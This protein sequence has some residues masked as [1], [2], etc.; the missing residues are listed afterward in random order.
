MITLGGEHGGAV[1]NAL[2]GG[3]AKL[4]GGTGS[5]L[6]GLTALL[7]GGLLLSGAS[8]GAVLRR[9]HHAVRRAVA[10]PEKV[11]DRHKVT[12]ELIGLGLVAIGLFLASLLYLGW[13][14]GV[15]GEKIE[16]G[17]RDVI[18]SAAY[19]AP[20]ALVVVGGLMLFRSALLDVNPFR[21]G[22]V[23]TTIGLMVTLGGD[24]GGAVGG[25]LG[26][27]VAK[28]L[29]GTGSVLLGLTALLAGALML[30]GASYGAVLR[31][32]HHAVRRAV[33]RPDR[34]KRDEVL[35][36]PPVL[37]Q[38]E[39]PID[40]VHDYPDVVSEGLS[41]PPPLL[42]DSDD[43]TE[44]QTALFDVPRAEGAY[45]LPDRAVLKVSPPAAVEHEGRRPAHG[46]HARDRARAL[47]RRGDDRRPDRR[48]A[49]HPLRAAAR[50]GNEGV[51]G[52]GPEGRPLLR[53]R[54]DR[55]PD[56]GADPRQAGRRRRGAE[57]G[58]EDRH[59]RRHLRRPALE[60]Q[61]ARRLARQ[62]HLR[63]RRLGRPGADAAHPDRGH[64]RLRQVGLHQ[65]DPDV[66]PAPLDARTTCG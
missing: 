63:H 19:A 22:L 50:A 16:S 44:E 6:L 37:A 43:E 61:P 52:R 45:V 21:T 8:Y 40:V 27:G 33:A 5:V 48:P 58:A 53:A 31:R 51:E 11:S 24:Q 49:R 38:H 57:P 64:H 36:P 20:L 54:D 32:S 26:G 65:H 56:P 3:V 35:A 62:G 1:G 47:R 23:I 28:L 9:S 42:V 25:A 60:R 39:P 59:A 34:P 10:R 7:A 30:S 29:G 41:E 12:P 66:D 17:L 14:G 13:E 55:D 15:A 4:L 18:G 46:R 2:G